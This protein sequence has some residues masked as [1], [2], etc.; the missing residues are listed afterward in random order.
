MVSWFYQAAEKSAIIG[1]HGLCRASRLQTYF[2]IDPGICW[3][4][5]N[6]I[7][8]HR[9][10]LPSDFSEHQDDE[11]G[12]DDVDGDD[13]RPQPRRHRRPEVC[14]G[15]PGPDGGWR[16]ARYLALQSRQQGEH[17]WELSIRVTWSVL[18]NQIQL[19]FDTELKHL[20]LGRPASVDQG[21]L[22]TRP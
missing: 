22:R 7:F 8:W 6:F 12:G 16:G 13:G 14:E 20:A 2:L 15:A 19:R 10:K 3:T 9:V 17:Q 18:A 4:L 11:G 21:R 5:V 1:L